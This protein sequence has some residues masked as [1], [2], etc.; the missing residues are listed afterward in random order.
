MENDLQTL[1]DTKK[2]LEDEIKS[3][4]DK[5]AALQKQYDEWKAMLIRKQNENSNGYIYLEI[6][7]SEENLFL[8][9]IEDYLYLL[10]YKT[11]EKENKTLPGNKEDEVSRKRDVVGSLLAKRTFDWE[12]SASGRKIKRIEKLLYDIYGRNAVRLEELQQEGFKRGVQS[13]H[14]KYCFYREEYMYPFSTSPSDRHA[15]SN[16]VHQLKRKLFLIPK[17]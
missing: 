11:L 9:E 2:S 7:C 10:L 4:N 15:T 16:M 1:R 13:G 14:V 5:R 8:N 3:L 6:P 17:K 12:K